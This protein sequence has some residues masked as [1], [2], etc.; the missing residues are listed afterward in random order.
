MRVVN[1]RN[2]EIYTSQ[3]LFSPQT[4]GVKA[5]IIK[6]LNLNQLTATAHKNMAQHLLLR[7]R[8][9]KRCEK[10]DQFSVSILRISVIN[11]CELHAAIN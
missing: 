6:C 5:L 8:S 10:R 9:C 4:N 7:S 3:T 2:F 11:K 1:L